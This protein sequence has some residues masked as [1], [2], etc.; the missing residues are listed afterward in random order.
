MI[1]GTAACPDGPNDLGSLE[2]E[3]ETVPPGTDLI[4]VHPIWLAGDDFNLQQHPVP[5][6]KVDHG[7]ADDVLWGHLRGLQ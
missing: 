5:L 2:P 6:G 1:N 4:R 7:P 3:V